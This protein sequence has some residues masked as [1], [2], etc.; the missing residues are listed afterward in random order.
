MNWLPPQVSFFYNV[1][2]NWPARGRCAFTCSNEEL[3]NQVFQRELAGE[4]KFSPA[5]LR[6]FPSVNRLL[7]K[8]NDEI[9]VH[10]TNIR[11]GLFEV[12]V[13]LNDTVLEWRFVSTMIED[14]RIR[15]ADARS[16]PRFAA[17]RLLAKAH[18]DVEYF[19]HE[20]VSL[21]DKRNLFAPETDAKAHHV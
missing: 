6:D 17:L 5:E 12:R 3:L 16:C 13:C 8:G 15:C 9:T 18:E 21:S 10:V 2:L 20:V 4:H 14:L 11:C 1:I 19:E 7:Q